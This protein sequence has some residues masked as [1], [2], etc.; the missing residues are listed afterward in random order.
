MRSRPHRP[1]RDNGRGPRGRAPFAARFDRGF[2]LLEIVIVLG[3][4][5]LLAGMAWPSF[6]SRIRASELPESADRVKSMLH[7]ARSE[8]VLEHR[9]FRIRFEPGVQQP[10][11]EWEPDPIFFPGEWAVSTA[12]WTREPILLSDV[13]IHE[14][15]LGR[16]FWTEPLA[17]TSDP[18]TLRE[19]AK[20]AEKQRLEDEAENFSVENRHRLEQT[21]DAEV[22]E[23]RPFILFEADGSTHW[24]LLIIARVDPEE[25]LDEDEEQLWVLLDGRTGLAGV[26]EK[27]TEEQMG[28]DEFFVEREKLER[29]D[30]TGG[31]DLKDLSFSVG[32]AATENGEMLT[33]DGNNQSLD[34]LDTGSLQDEAQ[35]M[36]D[37]ANAVDDGDSES[38]LD[39]LLDNSDLTDE[40][41]ENIR[42]SKAFGGR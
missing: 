9:R 5:I 27:V 3:L 4:L 19:A 21:E 25:E 24:A 1:S 28:D 15:Q 17:S 23:N 22:D 41:R 31:S 16:P 36:M 29:S 10:I 33:G 11:F 8:A 37:D 34:S 6:E 13:Q 26:R 42:K 32:P 20:E 18:D 14:I 39:D 38:S 40:E 30:K 7:M 35:D 12:G 2:T